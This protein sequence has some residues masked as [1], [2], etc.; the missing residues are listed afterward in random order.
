VVFDFSGR[1]RGTST[2]GSL[3]SMNPAEMKALS[4]QG[5]PSHEQLIEMQSAQQSMRAVGARNNIEVPK[6][7]FYPSRHPDPRK[8]RKKDIKQARVLLKPSKRSFFNPLRWAGL[9]YRYNKSAGACVVDGCDCQKLIQYDNL[10]AKITDEATGE[11]LWDLYW[12][13]P[14]T[15]EP[16][17]FIAR[18]NVTDG[19]LMRGTYCP[20]HLHLY[21]LLTKWE[22]ENEKER[23]KTKGGMREM[24]RKGVSTVAVPI[25]VL[26]KKNNTPEFLMKYE[27]FFVELEKD[28][29]RHAGISITHY[30]NPNNGMNDITAVYF[31][32]RYFHDELNMIPTEVGISDAIGSVGIEQAEHQQVQEQNVPQQQYTLPQQ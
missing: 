16:T 28:S 32:L 5:N 1:F 6:V 14:V 19:R 12:Q 13:N 25:S 15:G 24:V 23:L 31:D 17:A 10:Y 30:K 8:A 21:H 18:E 27:P 7:N 3:Q 4:H 22:G 26:K 11:S 2:N 20:E 9:K 29:K